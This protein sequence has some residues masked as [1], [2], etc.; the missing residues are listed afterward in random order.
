MNQ[1]KYAVT[2]TFIDGN[3][4]LMYHGNSKVIALYY[5]LVNSIFVTLD[6]TFV[7]MEEDFKVN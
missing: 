4:A 7:T 2:M 3:S 5:Y 6:A 1:K